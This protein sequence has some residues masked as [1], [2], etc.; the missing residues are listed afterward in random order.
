MESRLA[1]SRCTVKICVLENSGNSCWT[2]CCAC[3]HLAVLR[4]AN[5]TFL[6]VPAWAISL[7]VAK[8][9]PAFAHVTKTVRSFANR[10]NSSLITILTS[11]DIKTG[12][13]IA[14][15]ATATHK[16]SNGERRRGGFLVIL[17][18]NT[19]RTKEMS[20]VHCKLASLE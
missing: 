14:K 3:L 5:T 16:T 1:K 4:H 7:T 18:F 6:A 11:P 12:K 10:G 15:R 19:Q 9:R 20:N 17:Y 13:A 8:P 2:S